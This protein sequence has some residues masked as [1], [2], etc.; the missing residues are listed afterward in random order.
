MQKQG[1]D[2]KLESNLGAMN[3]LRGGIYGTC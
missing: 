1:E 3:N 2:F